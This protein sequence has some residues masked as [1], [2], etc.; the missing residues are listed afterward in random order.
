M[1]TDI[2]EIRQSKNL[3]EDGVERSMESLYTGFFETLTSM[4]RAR[5]GNGPPDPEDVAQTAFLKMHGS[6]DWTTIND[7]QAY[8]LRTANNIAISE[9]RAL[10]VRARHA[11]RTKKSKIE[12]EEGASLDV[13]RVL[14]SRELL[15]Q[16]SRV[17]DNLSDR[18]RR[19]FEMKRFDE[20]S[21]S[22]IARREGIS[23][24]AVSKH[25]NRAI[26]AVDR[27]LADYQS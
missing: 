18:Q 21:L 10:D 7:P 19:I 13:E 6:G 12:H 9:M 17:I 3:S 8:L 11:D 24:T 22:E 25:L 5:F 4:V 1:S 16:I 27:Y 23:R 26:V 15:E 14:T 2:K 20:L